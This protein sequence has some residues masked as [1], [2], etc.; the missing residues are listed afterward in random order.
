MGLLSMKAS[1]TYIET[2]RIDYLIE[3]EV[4]AVGARK[5]GRFNEALCHYSNLVYATSSPGIRFLEKIQP[6]W[7]FL[8]PFVAML[9]QE[10]EHEVDPS[11]LGRARIE[12]INRGKLATTLEA[13]G[14]TKDA[15]EQYRI[16][17][18]L[19]DIGDIQEVKETIRDIQE[20][21]MEYWLQ[22]GESTR[23]E[24]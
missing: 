20:K 15:E 23:K 8:F 5:D 12:G 2:V 17:T 19:M 6:R 7:S 16:A 9:L 4:L 10:I 3:Q 14:R 18:K 22:L 21:T 1:K 13:L 24:E 11:N